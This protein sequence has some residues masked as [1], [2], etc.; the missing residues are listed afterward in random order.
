MA[1]EDKL[2]DY[3]RRVTADLADAKQQ[4]AVADERHHEPVAVIGMACRYP[5]AVT[6]PEQLWDV[7]AGEVDATGEFPTDRGWDLEKLYNPDPDAYGT[8]Y[9][10]RGGFIDDPAG[11]DA[12][13]FNMSPRQA[14]A[15]DPHHRLFLEITWEAFERAGIDPATVRGD[16]VGIWSGMMYDHYSTQFLGDMPTSVEGTLMVSSVPSVL[17]GRVAYTFGLEGPA[18]TLD[19]A[20]SSSL[21]ALD[22]AVQALRSGDCPMALAGGVTVMAVPDPFVEF[23]RQRALATDGRCKAFSDDADG[24]VWAEGAGVLLLERLSDARRNGRRILSVIRG[25][26]VNQDGTSNGMTAPSGRAQERVIRRALADAR[27]EPAAIDLVEAHGTGTPLG[28]PIEATAILATYGQNRPAD[29]PLWLGSLKSNIGHSQAAA[30]VG[31]LIKLIMAMRHGTMPRTVNV[32]E[33]THHVDWSS[34]AV[35]LLTEARPWARLDEQPR[36]AGMSSFGISGTNAHVI[37]EEPTE[38]QAPAPAAGH[39]G[40]HA[41]VISARTPTALRRQARRLHDRVLA[42]AAVRPA[43]IAFSLADTRARFDHRAVV[44]GRDRAE[45]VDRLAGYVDGRPGAVVP[46][47]VARGQVSTTFL[48]TGQGGQRPGMG[49]DLYRAF[50]VFAAAFDEACAALD[51]YLERPLREVMWAEPNTAGAAALNQTLYTQ[52]ALFVYEVAA[53]RLL[54]SLGVRPTRLAGHSVGEIAAAHVAGIWTLAD[55]ARLV[56]TR[57]RL[58]QNLP[59]DGAMVAVAAP[60]AEVRAS[61]AGMEHLVGIAAINSPGD[62]VVSGDEQS[63]LAVQAHWRALGKRT[64]R[65]PVSHAFHSPLMEPMLDEFAR[66]LKATSFG[67]AQLPYETNLGPERSWTDPDYWV[68]QIRQT[69]GFAPMIELLEAAGTDVY[70]EVGPLPVLSGMAGNCLTDQRAVVTATYRRKQEEL[71]ALHG[72]LAEAFVVG[73]PVDWA[74][75]AADG[76]A[77]DLPTYAF[78]RERYWLIHRR[79]SAD[80]ASAGLRPVNHPLLRAAVDVADGTRVVVTGRVSLTELPW[81][82]D[83]AVGGGVVVPGAALL[84]VVGQVG[85]QAGLAEVVELTFEAPLVLP[86]DGGLSLQV[87]ADGGDGTVGVYARADGDDTWVRHASGILAPDGGGTDGRC[88][89]AT[90]WPPAGAVPIAFD[91]AYDRLA[92][93]G[94]EYGDAFRGVQAA[95][96]ADDA[97]Y[98]DV[99]LPQAAET[100]GFGLHPVLLDTAFHPYIFEGGSDELRLPFVFRG[101]RLAG[102]GASALRV[103]LSSDGADKLAVE[104]ADADGRLVLAIEELRVR[105]VSIASIVT[106]MGRATGPAGFFGLDWVDLPVA[107]ADEAPTWRY[108]GEPVAGLPGHPTVAALAAAVAG[109]ERCDFAVFSGAG[110]EPD[111][112]TAARELT[113][114]ALEAMQQWVADERLA[115]S[116]LVFLADPRSVRTGAVWGLVRAAQVEHPGRFVLADLRADAGDAPWGRLA[117]AVGKGES[118]C[119]VEAEKILVPRVSRRSPAP[120]DE[121]DLADGTVLV[122]GGTGGLGAL[123]ATRLVQRFGVQHL[124]LTSRRGPAA[125]GA[126]ELVA[127]LE[128]LGASVRVAACDVADAPALA[129]LLASVPADRPLTAVVH[130]AGV[131]DDALLEGLTPQRLESVFR[132]KAQA[133]WLLHELT[134]D[135]PLRA[136][137]LFSSIAGVLGNAGQ[138]NYAAANSFLDALAAHRRASGLPALSISWGMWSMSTG[139]AAELTAADEARLSRAGVAAISAEQGLDLFDTA[140]R[141][142]TTGDPLVV[143]C[144]WDLAALRSRAES[145]DDIPVVLRGLVQPALRPQGGSAASAFG[146]VARLAA[147]PTDEARAEIVAALRSHV[148]RVLAHGSA[149]AVKMDRTFSEMGFDSLTAVELRNRLNSELGVQL[150]AALVFDHPTVD[151]LAD[152]LLGELAPAAPAVNDVLTETLDRITA[153]LADDDTG[154][155]DRVVATLQ[156]AL[157]RL[158]LGTSAEAS[159]A[160]LDAASDEEIFQY[161]DTQL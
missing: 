20:C 147:L 61:L 118:Q 98:V 50:P 28:D 64:G 30:G 88:G 42:D 133:A 89:W 78:E 65:L 107:G 35:E 145:G 92:E 58:M 52:P 148:A 7:V 56:A 36:R 119:L 95:W 43:D 19:T 76:R 3:L 18:V 86:A 131:L 122:T 12:P 54:T 66:E 38:A 33:P 127:Q 53:F 87:V 48:F 71:E 115:G 8:S 27:L 59:A 149:A 11:F 138:G 21:V 80:V 34:G 112:P 151:A 114:R 158:G 77:V 159:K 137:V 155:R 144:R 157:L 6:T 141:E 103:R 2:R 47:G 69:V 113:G 39:P 100:E 94:Y 41:W 23:S 142:A 101:V 29:R 116:R 111:V 93:L 117:A 10:R 73:V 37:L 44:V 104:A 135:L 136:F 85:A 105:P 123:V 152:Y 125:S 154:E 140:L 146:P 68:D 108:L 82:A 5:G 150:P 67:A 75:L 120:V 143:A 79:S 40:P 130:A 13:F 109:G 83:H 22:L 160:Q 9:T 51:P 72:C 62:V 15:T 45:L 17:S 97:L 153:Q 110:T 32:T 90:S 63:C 102:H 129:E 126:A 4:L 128:G 46:A 124:L 91:G 74:A 156:A 99:A 70:L 57:A 134:A 16:R 81:L 31:G 132:P 96:R 139:M 121:L 106:A 161:I 84:D 49:R 26:A 24:A 60:A 55:A 1:I 25:I 14:L